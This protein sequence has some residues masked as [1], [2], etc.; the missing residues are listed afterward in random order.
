MNDT[1]ESA[2]KYLEYVSRYAVLKH[3]QSALD[4]MIAD[5]DYILQMM[6]E[7]NAAYEDCINGILVD[8]DKKHA[9][10]SVLAKKA[11]EEIKNNAKNLLTKPNAL[12]YN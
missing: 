5:P 6:Q 11:Y 2:K 7:Y 9:V 8:S 4:R 10:R 3:G 12:G 1:Y